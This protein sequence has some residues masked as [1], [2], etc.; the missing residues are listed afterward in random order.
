LTTTAPRIASSDQLDITHLSK[1]HKQSLI[2]SLKRDAVKTSIT[3]TDSYYAGKQ[4]ARLANLLDLAKQLGQTDVANSLASTLK[5]ELTK[6]L[7]GDYFYYDSKL[8]GVAA[9]TKAFGS[10]DFNDHH[11]H[12]GYFI[13]AASVLGRY[14]TSFITDYKAKVN[15]LVADIASYDSSTD[16]PIQRNYDPYAGHSWA[17]GLAPFADGNN[18]ESSSEAMNAWNAVTVWGQLIHNTSLVDSGSWM[19]ANEAQSAMKVW[20]STPAKT[21]TNSQFT[22]PLTSLNFSGKRTYSTFF[23]DES[24]PKL[25]IQ[26]IPMNPSMVALA[27]DGNAITQQLK[28]A[29]TDDNY[30]VPLG[31]YSLMYL[32]L[33][34]PQKATALAAKQQDT[35]IDDGNSR[36]YLDAW[37]FMQNDR[38]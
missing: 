36:T 10:E 22:S 3:A 34:D 27:G 33:H 29:I 21:A 4:L 20:R 8:H 9:Q 15:L 23:T 28:A 38:K 16:F 17:A 6:R 11:F 7:S 25:A 31:D 2:D 19:F 12:Y 37:L 1:D 30:N 14:D 5:A 24:N 32:A 35:F 26:L 18:Q 13:Y